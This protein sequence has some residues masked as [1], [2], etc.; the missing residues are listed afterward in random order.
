MLELHPTAMAHGGEAVARKDGKAHFIAGAMP[1]EVVEAAVTEDRGSWA[2]ARLVSV[3]DAS[4]DR[5]EPPCPHA[6]LCGGCQ[7]QH[8]ERSTQLKWKRDIVAGQLSHLGRIEDPPV[9][10]TLDPGPA[11]GYR[12]RMDFHV[13]DGRPGLM[14]HRSNDVVPLDSCPLLDPMLQPVFDNLG[15]LTGVDRITLRCGTQTGDILIIVEGELPVQ[16]ESWGVP[17]LQRQGKRLVPVVGEPRLAEVVDGTRFSIPFAGFFQNNTHGADALVKV[18]REAADIGEEETLLDGYCGV[19]LF[20]ATVGADAELVLGIDSVAD[21]VERARTN[22]DRAGVNSY[23]VTGS[24]TKDIERLDAYWDVAIVDPP[25]KGLGERGVDAV[26]STLPRRI[27]YVACDPASLARDSRILGSV[28]Y[29]LVEATPI[30][31]FPQTYHVE[32]VATFD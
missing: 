13:V 23:V 11:L 31:M 19:G 2:R 1:G 29:D 18:V 25:R 24:F 20:G 3:L 27:V 5:R 26:T 16:A 4:P 6:H 21:A 12:N 8:T 14:R 30:D 15:D 10:D 28:G 7:W 9:N 32:V 17:V 22:L